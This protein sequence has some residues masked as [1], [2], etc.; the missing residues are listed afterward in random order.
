MQQK[1]TIKEIFIG[2]LFLLIFAFIFDYK[3]IVD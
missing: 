2:L 1:F 3:E